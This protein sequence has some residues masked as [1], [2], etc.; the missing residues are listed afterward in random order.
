MIETRRTLFLVLLLV[1]HVLSEE[2]SKKCRRDLIESYSLNGYMSPRPMSMYV[3]P[4]LK[5]SCCSQYDQFTMFTA[6]KDKI[7]PKLLKYY[8]GIRKKY[9][10]LKE[11]LGVMFQIDIPKLLS[12]LPISEDKKEIILAKLT[13]ISAVDYVKMFNDMLILYHQNFQYMMKLR[14]SFFCVICD[15]DMQSII[16]IPNKLFRMNE[17][18]CAD[19]AQNTI[20]HSFFLNIKVA[21]FLTDL[22]EILNNFSITDTSRPPKISFFSNI[23]RNV[24]SCA[25]AVAKGNNFRP[26]KHYCRYF[27]FNANSPV[28][29]GYQIFFNEVMNSLSVFIK[30]YGSTIN[31]RVLEDLP[32]ERVLF[33][34]SPFPVWTRRDFMVRKD[35]YDEETVDPNFDDFVLSSMFNFQEDVETDRVQ[36]YI[37]F[38]KNKIFNADTEYDF[39]NGDDNDIFKTST[40]TIIDLENFNTRIGSPGIDV[41]KHAETTNI[42]NSMLELI[43]NLKNKSRFKIQYEKI[44]HKLLQQVNDIGNEEVKNFHRD[45]YLFFTDFSA[46][47]KKEEIV[48]QVIIRKDHA[49]AVKEAEEKKKAEAAAAAAAGTASANSTD[50]TSTAANPPSQPPADSTKTRRRS[51]RGNNYSGSRYQH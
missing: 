45:N 26:C 27:K 51:L 18:T 41:I 17:G 43:S 28:M 11:M 22:G 50:S 6:W 30:N 3:C 47:L 34:H 10:D 4:T 20:E 23:K 24:R 39:D 14:A 15:Y 38:V 49:A 8:D 44:D 12:G 25:K 33:D 42:D 29:E 32:S 40:N 46:M 13:I 37:N 7:K 9:V 35:P 36:A 21:S 19:I 16:N 1:G 5:M 31:K 48:D 2:E